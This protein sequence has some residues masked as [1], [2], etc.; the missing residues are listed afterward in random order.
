M[1]HCNSLSLMQCLP[2]SASLGL[3]PVP[4][5]AV[6]R[7]PI[8]LIR[9]DGSSVTVSDLRSPSP[10]AA[11]DTASVG[12]SEDLDWQRN[13]L[14]DTFRALGTSPEEE[15]CVP[16]AAQSDESND[17]ASQSTSGM[18]ISSQS[19]SDSIPL[20]HQPP[21]QFES[22][23]HEQP[24]SIPEDSS[25]S[26]SGSSSSTRETDGV[27]GQDRVPGIPQ[28]ILVISLVSASLT[29]ASCVFNTLMP[30]YM[31]TELKMTMRSMGVFEGMME[32]LS[33]VVRMFSG[34]RGTH[35]HGLALG[36][37]GLRQ[38]RGLFFPAGVVS[39]AMT[40]RK[41]AITAGFAMGAAAKFGLSGATEIGPLFAAKVLDKLGNGVQAA[42]RWGCVNESHA[43]SSSPAHPRPSPSQGCDDQ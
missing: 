5:L 42:P 21:S 32:A 39:D 3:G 34:E 35:G 17:R 4:P 41:A 7:G 31:V 36:L 27:Q 12:C 33:Y 8:T 18:G 15:D 6:F 1:L 10:D 11:V 13:R 28:P 43:G 38:H 2:L 19:S 29:M 20:A 26:S 37:H 23:K 16:V 24:P 22:Q 9:E 40:S 14:E 25:G 30:I